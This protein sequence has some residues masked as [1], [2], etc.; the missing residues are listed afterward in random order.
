[1]KINP[2]RKPYDKRIIQALQSIASEN[3]GS[4]FGELVRVKILARD[5]LKQ[6]KEEN[7]NVQKS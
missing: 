6:L 2:F 7:N 1:M 5:I 3:Y 4:P